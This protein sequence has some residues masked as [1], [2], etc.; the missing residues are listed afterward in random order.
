MGSVGVG[1]DDT[2]LIRAEWPIDDEHRATVR[3][4][5]CNVCATRMPCDWSQVLARLH[6][7]LDE[8]DRLRG[9]G[10]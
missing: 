6:A 1:V 2:E 10:S 3:P 9:E 8:I 5:R 7:A 4:G